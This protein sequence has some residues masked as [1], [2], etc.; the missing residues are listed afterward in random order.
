MTRLLPLLCLLLV[1]ADW[2]QWLGPKRDGVSTET[3]K[4]WKGK[5]GVLWTRPVGPGHSSPVIAGGKVYLHAQVRGKDA[6]SLSAFDAKTGDPLWST[7]YDRGPFWTLFGTGPQAT[8]AVAGGKAFTFGPTGLVTAFDADNGGRLWQ[9]DAEK[10]FKVKRLGFGAACSPLIDGQNVVVN[11]GGKGASV[12][13]FTADKGA[14]AWKSLD[15][16]ASYA[17]GIRVGDELVFLTQQG[18]HGL[19]PADGA[20][21]WHH[22]LV[23]KLDES[24]TTP[25][26]AGD[27]L[28]AASIT[29]GM[30]GVR[31]RGDGVEAVWKNRALTC[32]FSTPVPVGPKHVYVVTG[33]LGLGVSS[34]LHCVETAT[35]K[36]LWSK[37]RVGTYHAAMLRTA[38]DKLL[39][40]SDFGDLIL[41]DP[42]PA[43]YKELAKTKVT[44]NGGIWAHPA[45]SD[46]KVYLRDDK[47]LICIQMPE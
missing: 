32:Y 1:A 6:E 7:A 41:I 34:A 24:A 14:V 26:V 9:V 39:L 16:P 27:L 3:I 11:V 30:V 29:Q 2:P 28:L 12:V 45:L 46:G 47:E 19:K 20:P 4:P 10:E 42:D 31:R 33:K 13:A 18:L 43:G 23:D 5:L 25:V 35:G 15:D 8:P 38:D 36:I 44:K 22:K 40:L 17:S 21:L 37:E